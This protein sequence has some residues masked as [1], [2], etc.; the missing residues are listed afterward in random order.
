MFFSADAQYKEVKV[1]DTQ[2]AGTQTTNED[3]D[4]IYSQCTLASRW[5][6]FGSGLNPVRYE[7]SV[8]VKG[9]RPGVGLLDTENGPIWRD[10]GTQT[11]A[12]F[13]TSR[14][15]GKKEVK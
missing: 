13:T 7:W 15:S 14:K 9:Q 12:I 4:Y 1:Y 8:S 5:E 11:S 3:T 10:A 2:V 6:T